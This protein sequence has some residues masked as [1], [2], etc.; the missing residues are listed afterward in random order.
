MS[1]IRSHLARIAVG[2]ATA[3]GAVVAVTAITAVATPQSASAMS[4]P[5]CVSRTEYRQARRGMSQAQVAR[6]FGATGKVSSR[7]DFGGYKFVS[8]TYRPCTSR[9]GTVYVSFA[10][11]G[12]RTPVVLDSKFVVW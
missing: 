12:P 6:I 2:L 11:D 7:G 10:N 4:T 9:Y 1:R 5:G 8:R 3:V